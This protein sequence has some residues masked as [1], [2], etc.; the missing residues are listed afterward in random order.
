MD[1]EVCWQNS[2]NGKPQAPVFHWHADACG[3]PFNKEP[4]TPVA[5]FARR[6]MMLRV[7]LNQKKILWTSLQQ[8]KN[9]IDVKTCR[10]LHA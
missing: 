6:W 4:S 9:R 3:L 8:K 1:A 5:T 10:W 7:K 2:F